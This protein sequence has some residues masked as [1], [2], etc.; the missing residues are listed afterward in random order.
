MTSPLLLISIVLAALL[1]FCVI[2]LWMLQKRSAA[3]AQELTAATE[4]N[5][6]H[7]EQI[8]KL[9]YIVK[10]YQD[11]KNEL[12]LRQKLTDKL[13]T[14]ARATSSMS[15]LTETLRRI[16][17]I[18]SHLTGAE[19]GSL[20]L[21]DA[22]GRV[23]DSITSLKNALSDEAQ[24]VVGQVMDKGLAGWVVRTGQIAHVPDVNGDPRW[25]NLPNASYKAGSVLCVPIT[26]SGTII[27]VLT[28][29][30]AQTHFF[31]EEDARLMESAASQMALA[32]GNAQI[33]EGQRRILERQTSVYELLQAIS[34]QLD[35]NE[36]VETTV[37]TV[38]QLTG[39]PL[40]MVLLPTA[41]Q[42]FLHVVAAAGGPHHH[43]PVLENQWPDPLE[44]AHYPLLQQVWQGRTTANIPNIAQLTEPHPPLAS[45][46]SQLI[47][48][49]RRGKQQ[50]GL[51]IVGQE[52]PF[53]FTPEDVLLA[54]SM[55]EAAGLALANAELY[56]TLSNYTA[57]LR[58]LYAVMRTVTETII[59]D[60]TL[61]ET[62]Q[63]V[64]EALGYDAGIIALHNPATAQL[65]MAAH[66]MP[67]ALLDDLAPH[68]Q[69]T[70]QTL[71]Y[72]AFIHAQQTIVV[73]DL[74]A[75]SPQLM[76]LQQASPQAIP[77]LLHHGFRSCS[78]IILRHQGEALGVMSLY[79]RHPITQSTNNLALQEGIGQQVATAV[80]NARLFQTVTAQHGRLEAI[81]ENSQGGL[82]MVSPQQRVLV[83]NEQAIERLGLAG[84]R[85]SWAGRPLTD[86][87]EALRHTSPTAADQLHYELGR[88]RLGDDAPMEGEW[89]MPPHTTLHW[90]SLPVVDEG[91][92]LGRLFLWRDISEERTL[93]RLRE[94][95]IYTMV[96]DL[97]NPLHM[98]AGSIGLLEDILKTDHTIGS[99]EQELLSIS[100]QNTD[101]LLGLV[102]AILD[103]NHLESRRLPLNYT[104]FELQRSINS[105]TGLMTPMAQEKQ[106]AIVYEWDAQHGVVWSDRNLVERVLQNLVGNALKFTPVGGR[107][108]IHTAVLA[109]EHKLKISISDN[110]PGIDQEIRHRLFEK[111]TTGGNQPK[112]QGSGLGLAFCKMA[113]EALEEK[114]WVE[115]STAAG[116]T[117]A[118]TLALPPKG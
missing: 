82:V 5:R 39:W 4:T 116:T 42:T 35:H 105:I 79:G 67:Q 34:N 103:I 9:T 55:A 97:R 19:I 18:A 93:E 2:R 75:N 68:G 74:E 90:T 11:E 85:Q 83:I 54:D 98:I 28:L 47:I 108:Q 117:F 78:S 43:G 87:A 59:Q 8:E 50:F 60:Q 48:P 46:Q 29:I 109:S 53:A 22:A 36:I 89:E 96:H 72:Y 69:I 51:L 6:Q 27:G 12:V 61:K 106:I 77:L 32:L 26:Q 76:A 3:V 81:I 80:A 114:I 86:L 30:H 115:Q 52:K 10:T 24:S 94:D 113:L 38:V 63:V 84:T 56:T 66:T 7:N 44:L 16:L 37:Q 70:E 92:T 104:L 49:L 20:L 73:H 107:I 110:G 40:A 25:I 17:D 33:F 112:G 45:I 71:C 21:L 118:F 1:L 64:I 62:L 15:T 102:N 58:T 101:R 111:F 31:N 99:S 100:L 65:E 23:T 14:L 13:V 88:L 41:E 57:E 95:L 91:Q